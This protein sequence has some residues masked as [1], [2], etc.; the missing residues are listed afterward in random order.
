MKKLLLFVATAV[1]LAVV[2]DAKDQGSESTTFITAVDLKAGN[3]AA[4]DARLVSSGQPD[5]A[6]LRAIA[7]EGF[8]AVVDLR[9]E[10]EDRGFDEQEAV[11]QMGMVYA[12]LPISGAAD[13]TFDNAAVLNHILAN[14]EGRIL[15]HCA[16]G[17][18][19]G[20]LFALREKLLGASTDEAL[21]AGQAAGLTRLESVVKERLAEK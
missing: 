16:S 18:R 1:L 2:A 13:V 6:T 11:N 17:N 12:S 9:T 7:D 15:I 8:T 21:A 14:Y 20:A 10:T 19:V 3:A 5:E 4:A